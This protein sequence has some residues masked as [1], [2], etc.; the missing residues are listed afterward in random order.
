MH[1]TKTILTGR[2]QKSMWELNFL[3]VVDLFHESE[4]YFSPGT[5]NNIVEFTF[6]PV[7]IH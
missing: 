3:G 6:I 4:V 2:L 5:F 7:I 1:M